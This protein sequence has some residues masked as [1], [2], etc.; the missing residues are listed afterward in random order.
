MPEVVDELLHAM[1]IPLQCRCD[2]SNKRLHFI[3]I[4]TRTH[5]H[6][7]PL[8]P[9][10]LLLS[11]LA[12]G[13]RP[14][15]LLPICQAIQKFLDPARARPRYSYS[16][17]SRLRMISFKSAAGTESAK[18]LMTCSLDRSRHRD[19]ICRISAVIDTPVTAKIPSMTFG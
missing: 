12:F 7:A 1:R 13:F 8:H 9:A 2:H 6:E 15:L 19:T 17:F 18:A 16:F 4:C 5:V 14:H 10:L 3:R 11:L